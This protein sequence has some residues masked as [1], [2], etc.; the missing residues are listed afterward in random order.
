MTTITVDL[1]AAGVCEAIKDYLNDNP[2]LISEA[3][4]MDVEHVDE[5]ATVNNLEITEVSFGS[6]NSV[7][8]SYEFDWEYYHGCKDQRGAGH[9]EGALIG[10]YV[11]G[12]LE[13]RAL[14]RPEPRSTVDEF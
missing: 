2:D 9:V 4:D 1:E 11:D 10:K 13:F 7:E 3:I 5:R 14:E 6:D 12:S 8:I